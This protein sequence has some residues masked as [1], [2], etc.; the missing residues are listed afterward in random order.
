MRYS[1]DF[2]VLEDNCLRA[3]G[4]LNQS[5]CTHEIITASAH[6]LLVQR[7][8]YNNIE[9]IYSIKSTFS[10]VNDKILSTT[11]RRWGR[12]SDIPSID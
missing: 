1:E 2:K 8:C 7:K 6:F 10:C 9:E 4:Q 12:R 5:V 3:T 11:R